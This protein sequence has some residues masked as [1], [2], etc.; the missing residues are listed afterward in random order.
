MAWQTRSSRIVYQN[1]WIT[2]REDEVVRPDG[3]PGIYG[4]LETRAP[5]VF[6][7]A[8]TE[9]DEVVLLEIERYTMDERSLEVPGGGSDPGED[10]LTAARRELV[11]E[12]GLIT[13]DWRDLGPVF[14]L[15]GIT[16]SPGRV[17]LA[18]GVRPDP[19]AAPSTLAEQRAEGIT[20]VRRVP[21]DNLPG[22]IAAGGI[23][24]NEALGALLLALVALGRV[25]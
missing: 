9:A 4:V 2:V 17:L 3:E 20:D 11:E 8:I 5:S 16:R 1:R 12:T 22:L 18:Q 13:D 14:S 23:T 25:R 15:N 24:D 21:L 6:A 19:E 7:V 10:P